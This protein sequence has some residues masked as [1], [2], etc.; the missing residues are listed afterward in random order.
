MP[1]RKTNRTGMKTIRRGTWNKDSIWQLLP[2]AEWKKQKSL[3]SKHERNLIDAI[4]V[5][6]N[7]GKC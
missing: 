2:R 3:L 5:K 1:L 7:K 4:K 6:L